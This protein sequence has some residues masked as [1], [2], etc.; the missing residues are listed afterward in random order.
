M[1]GSG[2]T[3]LAVLSNRGPVS[4]AFDDDGSLRATRASGGM[5]AV[6]GPGVVEHD[7]LWL[8]TAI[9]DA[10][11]QATAA[12]EVAAHGYRTRFV[13]IEPLLFRQY[14]DVIANQTLWFLHHGLWDLPRR[15]RFDRHWRDAWR[16]YVAVNRQ[17]AEAAAEELAPG[18]TVLI[19][20]Y[21]LS[22]VGAQL[23]ELRPDVRSCAFFHIPFCQPAELDVLPAT[24]ADDLLAGLAGAGACGFHSHRWA[25]AFEECCR[26]RGIATPEVFASAAAVDATGLAEVAESEA[27]QTALERLDKV[28][29]DRRL[30]VRADRVELSKNILRGFY[31]FDDLLAAEPRWRGQVVF[32]AFVYPSRQGMAEY[33]GYRQEVEAVAGAINAKWATPDWTP[34]LLEMDDNYPR[35]VAALR[36]YDVL[37]VNPIRDGLNLVAK[38]GPLV[39]ER[40][41]VLLLS[42]GAGVWDEL[43]GHAL[44]AHP[45]DIASTAEALAA[46]LEMPSDE[47]AA[48]SQALKKTATAR[49]PV[50]WFADQLS[51]A[52]PPDPQA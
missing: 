6:V 18:A 32:G 10:D 11:R 22:L 14:Y 25:A 19:Q 16:S 49:T 15:P 40:D 24:V 45:F 21:Q 47:R 34:I 13:P 44:E 36:R 43:G 38:E 8:A 20:D 5:V 9:S 27:C 28:V 39:N 30:I 31:A 52:R 37:M 23:R 42:P 4:F 3:P 35:S 7:A 51:R 17:F 41:G 1:A 46:A 48:R 26:A 2:A 29:G 50:E 12:G 33:L